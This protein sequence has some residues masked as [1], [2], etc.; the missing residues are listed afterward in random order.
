VRS[1]IDVKVEIECLGG[2]VAPVLKLL[3]ETNWIPGPDWQEIS[4]PVCDFFGGTCDADAL[5][6]LESISSPFLTTYEGTDPG[7]GL[8]RYDV[9][10]VRWHIPNSHAGASS[11]QVQGRQLLVNGEPFVVNGMAYQP[12]A[13]GENWQNAWVDR[14]DRYS[15]DFPGIAASGANTV[16]LYA[17]IISTAMLDA[18]WAEGLYVIPTYSGVNLPQLQCPE[19][20]TFM[21]DRFEEMVLDWKDHPAI[22]FWLIGNEFNAGLSQTERCDP[23]TGW[24]PQLDAMAQRAKAVDPSHPV[25][26]ANSDTTGLVDVCE[27]GCSTDTM[28]PNLD[29]WGLQI[30]RGCTFGGTFTQYAGKSDCDKPLII[31]E[32]GADAWNSA[33]HCSVSTGLTCYVNTDCP[34]GTCSTTTTTACHRDTDCPASETCV[35]GELCDGAGSEDQTMQAGCMESLLAEADQEL[36][37]RTPGGVSSGQVIFEWADEW[38]KADCLPTTGWDAHDT[39][40]SSANFSYTMDPAINEEWWG[41]VSLDPANP[42]ERVARTAHT[43]VGDAWLGAVCNMQ[44][45]AHDPVSGDTTIAFDPA[46]GNAV[47]HNLYYG[48]LSAL[49]SYGYS[50]AVTG[51]DPTGSSPVTLPPGEL[52]WV[53]AAENGV[54]EEG[55]YGTDSAGIERPCFSGNCGV[56]QISGWNCLCSS[57]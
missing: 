15:V 7:P 24:Y 28:L 8:V 12:I 14:P 29:L 6:C 17:P 2:P 18:A 26:T 37:L 44:V 36:A 23:S 16:R 10:Y 30:Y 5:T 39:C 42:A 40:G 22:L 25:G 34:A 54:S 53:V 11:V 31:T 33:S 38:W 27:A 57:P 3:S 48:P 19:G 52:F 47:N 32:F 55:C 43:T 35:G 51:L 4:I 46:A 50:G 1:E 49:S 45:G 13:I 20:R 56:D 41:I 9:D 21:Q